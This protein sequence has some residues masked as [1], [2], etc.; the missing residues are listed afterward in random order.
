[1]VL[2]SPG[3]KALTGSGRGGL[4]QC[5]CR[6]NRLSQEFSVKLAE[7]R[8]RRLQFTAKSICKDPGVGRNRAERVGRA[9]GRQVGVKCQV[10]KE[11]GRL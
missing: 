6:G 5:P 7:E 11:G 4:E 10:V 9:K 8:G 1:M 3:H 2:E